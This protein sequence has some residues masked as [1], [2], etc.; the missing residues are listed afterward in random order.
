MMA[1]GKPGV[2]NLEFEKPVPLP[3]HIYHIYC[4]KHGQMDG[5]F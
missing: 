5:R 2:R 4:N 3:T 1:D